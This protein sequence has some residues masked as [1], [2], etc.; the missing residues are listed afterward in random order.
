MARW[1]QRQILPSVDK[2]RSAAV[3]TKASEALAAN[4]IIMGTGISGSHMTVHKAD[5][6]A[7]TK[8]G[9]T[10]WIADFAVPINSI[11]A[12]AVPWKLLTSVNT[13]GAVVGQPV[14]LS[15]T[16]GAWTLAPAAG[17]P[18][19][20]IGHVVEVHLTAGA[21]LLNPGAHSGQIGGVLTFVTTSV[22]APTVAVGTA[23]N[24]RPVIATLMSVGSGSAV[25]HKAVVAG[26][27]L[28]ITASASTDAG[29]V[30][31]LILG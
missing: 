15:D 17:K 11:V 30:S 21:V 9:G 27:V 13:N 14:Y 19:V 4:D 5:V 22:T 20:K 28:T 25:I 12:T 29:T 24:G 10:L 2:Q 7:F 26:G 31:Y 1:K 16:A 23:Y 6:D 3:K 18:L 8:M